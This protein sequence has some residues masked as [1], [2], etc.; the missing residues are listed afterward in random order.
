MAEFQTASH[1]F[2]TQRATRQCP[3]CPPDETATRFGAL[4]AAAP[5]HAVAP[6]GGGAIPAHAGAYGVDLALALVQVVVVVVASAVGAAVAAAVVVVAAVVDL[7]V[8][9]VFVLVLVVLVVFA[10]AGAG[11][12]AP[13]GA[14]T[15]ARGQHSAG[16]EYAAAVGYAKACLLLLL[17]FLS[18]TGVKSLERGVASGSAVCASDPAAAAAVVR[19][20]ATLFAS[21]RAVRPAFAAAAALWSDSVQLPT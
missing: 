9:L 3:A 8:P 6:P 14:R 15:A 19:L 20:A 1:A 18:T 2:V 4:G 10:D 21:S 11:A 16:G 7:V 5:A 17:L 12:P 13:L